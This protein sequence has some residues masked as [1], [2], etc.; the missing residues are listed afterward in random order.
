ME[1]KCEQ[2]NFGKNGCAPCPGSTVALSTNGGVGPAA[3]LCGCESG[4]FVDAG[5]CSECSTGAADDV[6]EVGRG[7]FE[8]RCAARDD[9]SR[10]RVPCI[11]DVDRNAAQYCFC[12]ENKCE[13]FE[14]HGDELNGKSDILCSGKNSCKVRRSLLPV[15][16]LD[17]V[18]VCAN[19]LDRGA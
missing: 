17:P 8:E 11:N 1:N 10:T 16:F 12:G 3:K 7:N 2:G 5:D 4:F 9:P 15:V 6:S 14:F 18:F 19:I 13:G